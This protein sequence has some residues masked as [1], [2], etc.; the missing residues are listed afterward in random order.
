MSYIVIPSCKDPPGLNLGIGIRSY[1]KIAD[2]YIDAKMSYYVNQNK[3]YSVKLIDVQTYLYFP[4]YY[5]LRDKKIRFDKRNENN[6]PREIES[7][8]Q[9]KIKI[10]S[11]RITTPGFKIRAPKINTANNGC[12]KCINDSYFPTCLRSSGESC[13][14]KI[15]L[16]KIPYPCLKKGKLR[17]CYKNIETVIDPCILKL[18][19]GCLYEVYMSDYVISPVDLFYL[20]EIK[21]EVTCTPV[22]T[23]ESMS[24]LTHG[25]LME[26]SIGRKLDLTNTRVTQFTFTKLKLGLSLFFKKIEFSFG[27][28]GINYENITVPIFPATNFLGPGQTL[29]TETDTNGELKI[30]YQ[31]Y[32]YT[33][34]F[35]N[36]LNSANLIAPGTP[37]FVK[38]ALKNT[39]VGITIGI[40]ICLKSNKCRFVTNV[41]CCCKPFKDLNKVTIAP[42]PTFEIPRTGN[43]IIDAATQ[44]ALEPITKTLVTLLNW[45]TDFVKNK[46]ENID[47]CACAEIIT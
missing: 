22:T 14:Q 5:Q 2:E 27:G 23:Y 8:F 38:N 18:V 16:A 15:T 35:Y 28:L 29:T 45:G 11:V 10:D 33:Y 21:I 25:S 30:W 44:K 24:V 19:K 32:A 46:I 1:G 40:L 17:T 6:K 7:K 47:A 9:F 39:D 3:L 12:N 41:C 34:S 43:S 26:I 42:I 20:P 36:I 37:D 4:I 13:P 31:L